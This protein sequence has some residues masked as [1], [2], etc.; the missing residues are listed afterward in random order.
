[1][2][3]FGSLEIARLAAQ[4]LSNK[5]ISKCLY[6]SDNTVRTQLK[7]IFE[8]L[9]I[10]SRS[11]LKQK[12]DFMILICNFRYKFT[13]SVKFT[14]TYH[15]S[16]DMYSQKSAVQYKYSGFFIPT[17]GRVLISRIVSVIPKDDYCLT[18]MIVNGKHR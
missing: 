15:P 4:G 16:G 10:N 17:I 5:E 13:I 7:I 8:K 14:R 11:L 18:V 1:M 12:L 3:V 9:G 2:T 6:I